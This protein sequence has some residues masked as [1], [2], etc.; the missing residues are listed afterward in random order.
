YG[1]HGST[2]HYEPDAAYVKFTPSVQFRFRDT[3][4]R[5]NKKQ[6]LL[7]RYVSV[8]REQSAYNFDKQNEDYSVFN[9]RYSSAESEIIRHI[10]YST[11]LQIASNFGKLAG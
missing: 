2:Y 5:K 9:A 10:D 11:D 8:N 3:D 1:I 7:F 6:F 4:L